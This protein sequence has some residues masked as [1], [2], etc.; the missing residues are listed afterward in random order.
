M[1][2]DFFK[3]APWLNIPKDRRGEILIEQ[4]HPRGGLLGGTSKQDAPPKSKLA[5]LAAARKR[6]N[7]KADNG[8][9][10]TSSV[11]LLD[12]LG[13]APRATKPEDGT[14]SPSPAPQREVLGRPGNISARK[15]SIRRE[16]EIN[17]PIQSHELPSMT[18]DTAPHPTT[19]D[20]AG[21]VPTATPSTFARTILGSDAEPEE[22]N[23]Y[24]CDHFELRDSDLHTEFDFVGPSPDDVVLNAQNSRGLPQKTNKST[25]QLIDSSK[26]IVNITEGVQEVTIEEQKVKGK[27]LDVLAEFEKSKSKDAANFVVIGTP[28]KKRDGDTTY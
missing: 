14:T 18:N 13:A 15:H 10:I 4:L 21:F 1:S 25:P 11:A 5:A 24:P 26:S 6:E 19:H 28:M 12:R 27:N 8:R 20:A 22:S 17:V 16:Q 23:F 9:G 7:P 3:D 2:T